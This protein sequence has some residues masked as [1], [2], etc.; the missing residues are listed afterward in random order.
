MHHFQTFAQMSGTAARKH[1]TL[2]CMYVPPQCMQQVKE[3]FHRY[4]SSGWSGFDVKVLIV[5]KLTNS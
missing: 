2:L 1:N 3:E 5:D 4:V